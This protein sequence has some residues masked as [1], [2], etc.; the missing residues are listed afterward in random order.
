[1]AQNELTVLWYQSSGGFTRR[2]T[3]LAATTTIFRG[4]L[5]MSVNGTVNSLVS[6]SALN[7]FC[8]TIP[9]ADGNGGLIFRSM[10]ANTRV[11]LLGGISQTLSVNVSFANAGFVDV[12]IQQGTDGGGLVTS[13]ALLV[14]NAVRAHGLADELLH[15]TVTG[16][17]NGLT[18]TA[19]ATLI[20]QIVLLGAAD[21][22][23]INLTG[24]AVT[25]N[26]GFK[27]GKVRA[28]GKT[29]D[30]PV[31]ANIGGL[32]TLVDDSYTIAAT[33]DPMAFTAHLLDLDF[34]SVPYIDLFEGE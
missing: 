28:V 32:V 30:V 16:T 3:Q 2:A 13:T 15:V 23:Y 26:M 22:T 27:L 9:G 14:A 5:A 7:A 31:P 21:E 11:T 4:S 29:G 20:N 25:L 6:G 10:Q 1:M 19:T 8:T 24:S 18:A 12:I 34:A 33:L 17:G